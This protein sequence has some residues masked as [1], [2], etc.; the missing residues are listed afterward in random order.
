MRFKVAVTR[1]QVAE[2]WIRAVDEE[3]A[4]RKVRE[5]FE[6]PYAYFGHWE[7]KASEIDVIEAEEI[8]VVRS[9]LLDDSGPMLLSIKDAAEALGIPHRA[10]GV[11][12]A[13]GDIECTRIGTRKYVSRDAIF[14][15][16][17]AN[18]RRG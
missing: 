12:A 18:T 7:T 11:L 14:A 6:K 2:R 5:E 9:N 4:A 1:V 3:D 17:Q 16:V 10:L 13:E 15:F 8:T